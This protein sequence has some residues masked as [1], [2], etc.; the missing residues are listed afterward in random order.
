MIDFWK[1]L[2]EF[3]KDNSHLQLFATTHSEEF[4]EAT[5]VAFEDRPEDLASFRFVENPRK[6]YQVDTIPY[7]YRQINALHTQE[8]S[9]T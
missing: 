2:L 6:N 1:A 3:F 7:Q 5:L 9:L 8:S 4:I